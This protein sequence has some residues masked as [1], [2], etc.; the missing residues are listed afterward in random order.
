[1]TQRYSAI[2]LPLNDAVTFS[3]TLALVD[4]NRFSQGYELLSSAQRFRLFMG[5]L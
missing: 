5:E 4:E 1:V 2:Y 3:R